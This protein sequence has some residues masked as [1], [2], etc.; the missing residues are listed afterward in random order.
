M[1]HFDHAV[2]DTLS[3]ID[4]KNEIG[5]RNVLV[6]AP[7][8]S[9]NKFKDNILKF[10]QEKNVFIIHLNTVIKEFPYDKVFCSS[11]KRMDACKIDKTDEKRWI[12]TSNLYLPEHFSGKV[13][14]YRTLL[15][16]GWINIDNAGILALRLLKSI[17]IKTIYVAGFDGYNY[18]KAT[19]FYS[20]SMQKE[21][22]NYVIDRMNKDIKEMMDDV[23]NN[24]NGEQCDVKFITPSK[25]V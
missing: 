18:E 23:I 15:K 2:D 19:N 21:T 13:M 24:S 10:I 8:Q 3:K 17:G 16:F 9:I 22:E 12:V 6:I 7:G 5:T 25:Y 14:D 20:I 11:Q 4:L 1:D